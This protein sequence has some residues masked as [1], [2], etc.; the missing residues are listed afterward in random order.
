MGLLD[1]GI[2]HDCFDLCRTAQQASASLGS[3]NA[4]E[5]LADVDGK[6]YPLFQS[7]GRAHPKP[8]SLFPKEEGGDIDLFNGLEEF[9]EDRMESLL[10]GSSGIR[11]KDLINR[12]EVLHPEIGETLDRGQCDAVDGLPKNGQRGTPSG[13]VLLRPLLFDDVAKHHQLGRNR[14]QLHAYFKP[15]DCMFLD[16]HAVQFPEIRRF[17]AIGA[18]ELS[19]NLIN[20]SVDIVSQ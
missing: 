19:Y 12:D 8:V 5:A 10:Q 4:G 15:L 2:Q 17:L 20:E 9:V 13:C 14:L 6:P 16:R 1:G 11:L 3:D 7:D 18:L